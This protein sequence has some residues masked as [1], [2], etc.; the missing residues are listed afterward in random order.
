MGKSGWMQ[1]S[2]AIALGGCLG[3]LL[4]AVNQS[5]Y[6]TWIAAG[7]VHALTFA[8]SIVVIFHA[9]FGYPEPRKRGRSDPVA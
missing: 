9:G 7:I 8:A 6:E 3:C 5:D 1:P 4:A 2:L